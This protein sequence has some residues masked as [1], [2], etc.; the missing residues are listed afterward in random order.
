MRYFIVREDLDVSTVTPPESVN[1]NLRSTNLDKP[2][3]DEQTQNDNLDN[4]GF[5]SFQLDE[6]YEAKS[7]TKP[8]MLFVYEIHL[9]DG[10]RGLGLGRHLMKLV[11]HI[12]R[13]TEMEKVE[14]TVHAS[15]LQAEKF[16]KSLGF[17]EEDMSPIRR[18]RNKVIKAEWRVF[19]REISPS[20]SE[21]QVNGGDAAK[22]AGNQGRA[23]SKRR[24]VPTLLSKLGSK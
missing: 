13:V 14:L 22:N 23:A 5:I 10:V 19:K 17:A 7:K 15:N 4:Y 1:D 21:E 11:E 3:K 6:D 2:D 9:G 20:Q 18:L 8:V 24:I 12:A 16:Y